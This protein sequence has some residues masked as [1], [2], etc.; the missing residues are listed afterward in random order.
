MNQS[1]YDLRFTHKFNLFKTLGFLIDDYDIASIARVYGVGSR[2]LQEIE[3][4]IINNIKNISKNFTVKSAGAC[5]L[6]GIGDSISSDRESYLKII[7]NLWKGIPGRVVYDCA[8]SGEKTSEII[9]RFYSTILSLNFDWAVVFLGTNDSRELDDG[10]GITNIS[11]D[12]YKRNMNYIVDSLLKAGKKVI[13]VTIPPVDN[14]R[15]AKFFAGSNWKY[16]PK[17]IDATNDYIRN[18][19]NEKGAF[20]ADLSLSINKKGVDLLME[21]GIHLNSDGQKLLTG[22]ILDILP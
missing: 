22:L 19:S 1:P 15:L 4:S 17:R 9:N 3:D 5:S 14:I 11:L 10:S 2:E 12:E 6:A 8:V 13:I 18:L 20:L 16:S 21:D 7:G